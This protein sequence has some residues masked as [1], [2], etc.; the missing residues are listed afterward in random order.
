MAL[1]D[2]LRVA[3]LQ[4]LK[5]AVHLDRATALVKEIFVSLIRAL[6]FGESKEERCLRRLPLD[7]VDYVTWTEYVVEWLELSDRVDLL[8]GTWRE[9]VGKRDSSQGVANGQDAAGEVVR[10]HHQVGV[11]IGPNEKGNSRLGD[12]GS[13]P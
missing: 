10:W 7:Q 8:A 4:D 1:C 9:R 13:S 12:R 6:A 3:C 11:H 2:A 5:Q